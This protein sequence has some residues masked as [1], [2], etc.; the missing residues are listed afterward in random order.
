METR[1][2]VFIAFVVI[3]AL[4]V[5]LRCYEDWRNQD[6]VGTE[7]IV[8]NFIRKTLAHSILVCIVYFIFL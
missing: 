5:V 4:R 8:T 6:T 2:Y 1:M 3:V 7:E